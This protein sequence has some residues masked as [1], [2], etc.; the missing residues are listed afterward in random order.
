M[1]SRYDSRTTT[2]NP[3]GRLMQ[4][5]YAVEAINNAGSTVGVLSTEGIVFAA[6][7]KVSTKLL[8]QA[9]HSEKM[10][11]IDDH[12]ACAIAGLTSDAIVLLD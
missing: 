10:Y 6:E 8:E 9:R 1:S 7:R 11:I 4:V 3:E 12:I 5:E 2:F